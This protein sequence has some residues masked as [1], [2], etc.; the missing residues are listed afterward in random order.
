MKFIINESQ[1]DKMRQVTF[2][3]LD[4]LSKNWSVNH[5]THMEIRVYDGDRYVFD[6]STNERFFENEIHNV[7]KINS[8]LFNT[9]TGIFPL[10]S[11]YDIMDWFNQK[12]NRDADMVDVD[13][14][15][16]EDY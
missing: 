1:V 8:D 13:Y 5:F 3:Y 10:I 2:K 9:V 16:Y 12:Y 11:E 6:Y 7:L 4:D 15:D 14:E